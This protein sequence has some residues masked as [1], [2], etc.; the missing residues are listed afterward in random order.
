LSTTPTWLSPLVAIVDADVARRA[1]Y[2]PVSLGQQ[3]LASGA[4]LLQIRAKNAS[5]RELLEW[6]DAL[7]ASAAAVGGSL[8]VND[9]ADIALAARASGVHVGQDDLRVEAVRHMLGPS[10]I[11]GL[12]THTRAQVDEAASRQVSYVAV[13][14]V[15]D[16]RTKERSDPTVGVELVRYAAAK[17]G[18]TPIVAIGGI[19]LERATEVM[20]AGAS[21]VAVITD[22]LA[23]D[24]G[25]RVRAFLTR[26]TGRD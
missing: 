21:A 26:L 9:R 17:L 8:V 5:G 3:F 22:L 19:T 12:S 10:A 11:V 25:D 20:D 13:G 1:S 15:F 24:P 6:A 14:P 7:V 4:R 23:A 16:T 2:E 18:P